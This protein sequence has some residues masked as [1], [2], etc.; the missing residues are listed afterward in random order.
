MVQ[1]S[2][3]W[4][5]FHEVAEGFGIVTLGLTLLVVPVAVAAPSLSF[6]VTP[7]HF[8]TALLTQINVPVAIR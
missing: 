4:H 2:K 3:L 8:P 6:R 1:Y 7:R 5:E